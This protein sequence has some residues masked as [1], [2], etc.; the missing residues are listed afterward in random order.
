MTC[1]PPGLISP[2][3]YEVGMIPGSVMDCHK[4]RDH[5]RCMDRTGS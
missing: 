2:D 5:G 4:V 3:A 1:S